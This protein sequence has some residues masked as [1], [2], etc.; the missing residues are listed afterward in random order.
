MRIS[1]FGHFGTLNTGNESTLLSILSRLRSHYPDGDFICVCTA[2]ESVAKRYGIDAVPFSRRESR[3]WDRDVPW[4]KRLRMV[5]FGVGEELREYGRAYSTL[6][7][8]DAFI[9]P[10]TG[11]LTDA[12]G[13]SEWGPYNLFKWSLMA[14]LRRAKVLF[15]SVGAGPIYG[16]LGRTLLKGALSLA[17]YRSYRDQSTAD[18]L[19]SAGFD[20]STDGIYPDLVFGLPEELAVPASK[21]SGRRVVGLGLMVYDGKLRVDDRASET[22]RAYLETLATFVKWLLDHEYDV[23]LLL[24][25]GDWTVIDDFKSV[26]RE[27]SGTYDETRLIEEPAGSV[28]DILAQL[29]A[30]D[31]VVATRFHNVLLGLVLNRPVIAISLHHKS[32]SLMNQMGLSDYCLDIRQLT[33]EELVARFQDLEKSEDSIKRTIQDQVSVS[34]KALDE[35]Y[36]LLFEVAERA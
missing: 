11:L 35:Q 8:T 31:V 2:P 20:S 22:Y 10:G 15:V 12:Y 14:K 19:Q 7:D 4:H 3:I 17:D 9:I 30:S 28:K 5:V 18:C 33:S 16:S 34:S 27:R 21:Q 6:S 29:A 13:L 24:G 26:F 25:D 32:T 36:S 1:F 23:R